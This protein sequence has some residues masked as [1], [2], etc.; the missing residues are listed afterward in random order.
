M[1]YPTKLRGDEEYSMRKG[2]MNIELAIKE[3]ELELDYYKENMTGMAKDTR[4]PGINPR[5]VELNI[6]K[7]EIGIE[8]HKEELKDLQIKLEMKRS[9][10]PE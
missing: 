9:K 1:D 7:R 8:I 4:F 10:K 2:I 5:L 6:Q 3:A